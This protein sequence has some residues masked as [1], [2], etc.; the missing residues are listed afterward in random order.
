MKDASTTATTME[1]SLKKASDKVETLSKDIIA[2]ADP[3]QKAFGS[4]GVPFASNL[5]QSAKVH[6]GKLE[7]MSKDAV[8]ISSD[9]KD[10]TKEAGA[11]DGKD[12]TK[13]AE[14]KK[15]ESVT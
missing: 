5:M 3:L 6:V 13:M 15:A 7:K 4:N 10:A 2:E 8:A 9:I 14:A 12:F 11:L 1:Q